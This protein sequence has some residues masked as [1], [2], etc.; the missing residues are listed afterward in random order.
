[1]TRRRTWRVRSTPDGDGMAGEPAPAPT[2]T[3]GADSSMSAKD[4]EKKEELEAQLVVAK[5]ALDNAIEMKDTLE[6]EASDVA[7][8]AVETKEHADE[9]EKEAAS[10]M[11]LVEK[12]LKS[13]LGC[14]EVLVTAEE[15]LE[16]LKAVTTLAQVGRAGEAELGK[17]KFSLK[18]SLVREWLDRGKGSKAA[19]GAKEGAKEGQESAAASPAALAEDVLD[20]LKSKLEEVELEVMLEVQEENVRLAEANLEFAEAKKVDLEAAAQRVAEEALAAAD[21]AAEADKRAQAAMVLVDL[22]AS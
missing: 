16:R 3:A 6:N 7:Q 5:A 20:R 1:V 13:E 2:P 10:A 11:A 18:L 21:A 14:Q 19:E 17:E 15:E 12:A 9:K 8:A 4:K 22:N